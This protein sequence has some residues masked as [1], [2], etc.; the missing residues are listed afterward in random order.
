[1][2]GCPCCGADMLGS[3]HC[4]EC[5]CEEYERYCDRGKRPVCKCNGI[6]KRTPCPH[7]AT[8]ED[9]KCDH[10]REKDCENSPEAVAWRTR[11]FR[12]FA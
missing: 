10:C 3:D 1:M 12:S 4:P 5:G 11:N 9:G 6:D 7:L 2:N 8:Q